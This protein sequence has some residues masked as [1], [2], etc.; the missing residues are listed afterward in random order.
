ML[1]AR[2]SPVPNAASAAPDPGATHAAA[3]RCGLALYEDAWG[4]QTR[5]V[6][7]AP[8]AFPG[9]LAGGALAWLAGQSVLRLTGEDALTFLHSQTTNDLLQQPLDAA[10]WHGYCSPKGRLLAMMLAWRE[11]AS[12]RLL[13]P[14]SVAEPIHK[15]LAMFVLRSKV[16]IA[17]ESAAHV[18][19]GLIGAAGAEALEQWQLRA[20]A[21]MGVAIS[22]APGGEAGD[23]SGADRLVAIGLAPLPASAVEG[24]DGDVPRW[25]LVVPLDAVESVWNDLRSRL[26][27]IDSASWRWTDV[28]SGIA[29]IVAATSERFVPQM[30]NLE[31][32]AIG[33][34]SFT[35]G[36]YPGQE[37]VAR[38]HYLGKTKRR[39]FLGRLAPAAVGEPAPGSDVSDASGEPVGVVVAA[40]AS[41]GGAIDVL[42][43]ARIDA[44]QAGALA[45]DGHTL[46]PLAL[47]YSLP[48]S[49]PESP[50]E[51]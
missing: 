30:L 28:R 47:P 25:L 10:R 36:C 21:A 37:V 19:L 3:K 41:P 15:R 27:P 32:E 26:A 14:E 50:P 13:L 6:S 11:D 24:A 31:A 7:S 5:M 35:K 33:A 8:Q 22:E 29:S 9:P 42:Y 1:S 18:V 12:I 16:R 20:P 23:E 39:A 51:Q 48:E 43:E 46:Q 34:V 45:I 2:P 44:A 4:A 40:A 38:S 49:L 17:N